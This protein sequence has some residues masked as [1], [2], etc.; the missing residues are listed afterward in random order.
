MSIFIVSTNKYI[1]KA[2]AISIDSKIYLLTVA[3]IIENPIKI[4]NKKITVVYS[5]VGDDM[6]LLE[7]PPECSAIVLADE[8][9]TEDLVSYTDNDLA[10][11]LNQS[12]SPDWTIKP[13]DSG[14][15]VLKKGKCMGMVSGISPGFS[16]I[17]PIEKIHKFIQQ[18]QKLFTLSKFNILKISSLHISK[19]KAKNNQSFCEI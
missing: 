7:A 8:N 4:G 12:W 13:G 17:I 15:P 2:F 18:F 5:S 11:S 9:D 6:A 14:S 19:T 3:H 10:M 1:G 16:C